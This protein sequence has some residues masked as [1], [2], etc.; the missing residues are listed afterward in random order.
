VRLSIPKVVEYV[1]FVFGLMRPIGVPVGVLTLSAAMVSADGFTFEAILP[2]TW[3]TVL[4]CY[5]GFA[6]N[7]YFDRETDELNDRKGGVHGKIVSDEEKAL[8]TKYVNIAAVILILLTAATIPFK[9]GLALISVSAIS[10]AYSAPPIRLK[11]VPVLDSLSNFVM[12][13][14]FFFIGVSMAGETLSSVIDGAF[15]FALIYGGGGHAIGTVVDY[16]PDKKAGISTIGTFL[17]KKPVMIIFQGLI[18]LALIL[19][20][21]SL[22]TRSFILITLL[23]SIWAAYDLKQERLTKMTYLGFVIFLIYGVTWIWLRI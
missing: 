19:E 6:P 3:L 4:L 21:W 17:G 2:A 11:E 20:K 9:A 10:L 7:D 16:K 22:E 5:I 13:Y 12:A 1:K 15:W 8:I 23:G 14:L 18:I